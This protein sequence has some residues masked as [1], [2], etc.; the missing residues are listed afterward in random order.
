MEYR[1]ELE[2]PRGQLRTVLNTSP[3][4]TNFV[5][6]Q[7]GH[8]V[9][10]KGY[11]Q[12]PVR[13]AYD[14]ILSQ[15]TGDLF[16]TTARKPG[17][18]KSIAP[19]GIIVEYEDGTT[20]GIELGRRYGEAA[21]LT[22]PHE[23][24]TDL[25]VGATFKVGDTLAYNNGFFS[26]SIDDPTQV[27]W[28][29][30]ALVR[31]ALLESNKTLED[32]SSISTKTSKLLTSWA[33]KSVDVLVPFNYEVHRVLKVGT[34]VE[35]EDILCI[36]EDAVTASAGLFDEESLDTLRTVSAQTPHA[37]AK[38]TL[39][40]IEVYYHGDREDMSDTLKSLSGIS[41]REIAR[42]YRS[43]GKPGYTG[44]VDESFRV[45]GDPLPLDHA[46]LRFRI[47]GEMPAGVGD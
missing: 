30:A 14:E 10:C 26:K 27:V 46:V 35:T 42:R 19:E 17:V 7:H 22:I 6:V 8:G 12:L 39:E 25:K 32:A 38:G 2:P 43:K 24:V 20:K 47:T 34:Q 21:G 3:R 16:A 5:S 1:R 36:I 37:K 4:R 41:D 44:S 11:V 18:V 28:K 33:T 45:D 29:G 23:V 40:R 13:T 15:R 31:V 9:A